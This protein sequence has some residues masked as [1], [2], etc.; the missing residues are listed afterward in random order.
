MTP[1]AGQGA[2]AIEAR[3]DDPAEARAQ[4]ITDRR[5]LAEVSA[6]RAAVA[7]LGASCDTPVGAHAE[8]ESGR[9]TLR[10]FCG[11]PD[12]SEWVRDEVTDDASDPERLGRSLAE[13]MRAAGAAE[14]LERAEGWQPGRRRAGEARRGQGGRR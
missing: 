1:A 4:V 5:A 7:A 9:M 8:I 14:L 11:L 12:G 10:G 6:E 13:R 3:A 2:I